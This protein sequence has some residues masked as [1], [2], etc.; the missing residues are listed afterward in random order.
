MMEKYRKYRTIFKG[1]VS[2]DDINYL[3]NMCPIEDWNMIDSI[4]HSL[5]ISEDAMGYEKICQ[6]ID[7][8]RQFNY[9]EDIEK[10]MKEN[11]ETIKH[12][13]YLKEIIME[14]M[15]D[16]PKITAQIIPIIFRKNCPH[17]KK[18]IHVPFGEIYNICGINL[19]DPT[20]PIIEE[21]CFRDWCVGCGKKLCKHWNNNMLS[22]HE[23]RQHNDICCQLYAKKNNENYDELYCQCSENRKKTYINLIATN[24]AII[25]NMQQQQDKTE[26]TIDTIMVV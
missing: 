19:I 12:T 20:V 25:T 10:Y 8:V 26:L 18:T 17:C 6:V 13:Q 9:Y 16:K 23:N 14:I 4:I 11:W 21:G 15:N 7:K 24:K 2:M 22:R 1:L 5:N 3:K